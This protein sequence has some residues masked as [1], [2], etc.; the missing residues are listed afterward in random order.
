MKMKHLQKIISLILIALPYFVFSQ[1]SG[2]GFA[3]HSNGYIATNYHVIEGKNEIIVKGIN[4]DHLNEYTATV[5]KV[6]K[7]NDLAILKVKE[8]LGKIPYGFKI[9]AEGVAGRVYSYGY[10]LTDL[11]GDEVKFTEGTINANSGFNNDPRWY[12]HTA[13]IQPGNSGG[14]LFNKYGN[15]VGVNNAVINNEYIRQTRRTETTNINY[16]IKARYL[17]H[18]MEDMELN[19]PNSS[20]SNLDMQTQ[21]KQ[22]RK[23]VYQIFGSGSSYD[24]KKKTRTV[25]SPCG[26]EP[27]PPPNLNNPQYKISYQYKQYKKK[28]REW[29]ECVEGN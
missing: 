5:V 7:S 22:T 4:G 14:P 25:A 15:L 29:K 24:S 12:Q 3:I 26:E 6:D 19:T 8:S 16:A 18:L 2:T 13:T 27:Q 10:P 21:Y 23:F 20:I 28:H 9:A 1:A 17:V 11:L